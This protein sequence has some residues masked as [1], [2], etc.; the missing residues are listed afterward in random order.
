MSIVSE[1]SGPGAAAALLAEVRQLATKLGDPH[2]TAQLH[3]YVAEMEAKRGLN[4][5]A[6]RHSAIANR[7]LAGSPNAYLEAFCSNLELAIS[8]LLCQFENAETCGELASN[9]AEHSGVAKIRRAVLNNMASLFCEMGQFDRATEYF[10]RAFVISE[11]FGTHS[12]A[13]CD[14]FDRVRLLQGRFDECAE[15]LE[16]VE[17]LIQSDEDRALYGYRYAALTRAHLLSNQGRIDDAIEKVTAVS[18]LATSTGDALL[19]SKT[20]LTRAALLLR[21][22]RIQE[23]LHR[24]S[25]D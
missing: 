18:A 10:E 13:I 16:R 15:L 23:S 4:D 24:S 3:L 14:G 1:R 5:N 21:L 8:V 7:L 9:S 17:R 25:N 19:L 20:E 11:N 6:R 2:V 12:S 22:G